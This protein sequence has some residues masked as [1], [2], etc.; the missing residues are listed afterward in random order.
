MKIQLHYIKI[1]NAC[2]RIKSNSTVIFGSRWCNDMHYK[3]YS[4]I[5]KKGKEAQ[6]WRKY[7]LHL[8]FLHFR[9]IEENVLRF[10]VS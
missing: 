1:Y 6:K 9:Y 10:G 4:V 3:P 8:T 2:A 7:G 5:L